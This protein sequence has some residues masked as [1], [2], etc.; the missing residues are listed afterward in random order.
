MMMQTDS[1]AG[2]RC[3]HEGR[4]AA[5]H[6]GIDEFELAPPGPADRRDAVME[7]SPVREPRAA[8][9]VLS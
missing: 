3:A 2:Q 4:A 7:A 9:E 6:D 8:E 1:C 5:M